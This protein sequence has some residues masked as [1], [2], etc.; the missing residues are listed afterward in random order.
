M[1]VQGNLRVTD[2]NNPNFYPQ[3]IK[4]IS[5]ITKQ[6]NTLSEGFIAAS[7]SASTAAPT[8]G[9]YNQ[10]DRILNTAPIEAGGV[11]SKYVITQWICV[12][13]GSPGTWVACRSLT[14]N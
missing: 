13:S 9:S 3:L 7:T 11:G 2:A 8:A 6:L 14:G 1:R 4:V 10:G 12:A 5:D